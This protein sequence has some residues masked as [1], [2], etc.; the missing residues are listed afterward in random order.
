[1]D[2]VM[3]L[4]GNNELTQLAESINYLSVAQRQVK[5]KE[6]ALNKEK[7]SL[8]RTL[9]HDIRTSLTSIM[10]YSELLASQKNLSS[11]KLKVYFTLIQKRALRLKI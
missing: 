7:E 2:F 9:S 10:S 5:E 4:E 11:D 6:K 3:S 8:I 1:M